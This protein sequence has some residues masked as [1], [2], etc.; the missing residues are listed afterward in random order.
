MEDNK[1]VALIVL[2]IAEKNFDADHCRRVRRQTHDT[3]PNVS[4][5]SSGWN[6]LAA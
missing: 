6:L 1:Q 2:F 5:R 3:Y 4:F